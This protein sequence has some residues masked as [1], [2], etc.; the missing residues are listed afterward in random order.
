MIVQINYFWEEFIIGMH[1]YLKSLSDLRE[2]INCAPGYFKFEKT[3]NVAAPF[4]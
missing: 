3:Y 2:M 4:I 1:E